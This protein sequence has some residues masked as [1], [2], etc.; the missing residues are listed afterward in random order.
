MS[1]FP[2]QG[3]GVGEPCPVPSPAGNATPGRRD[4]ASRYHTSVGVQASSPCAGESASRDSSDAS[5]SS[6][7]TSSTKLLCRRDELICLHEAWRDA[8]TIKPVERE[9]GEKATVGFPYVLIN[10]ENNN[11]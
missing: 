1:R 5:S 6:T 3:G 7:F 8:N 2:S 11:Y 10:L 9:E 4:K